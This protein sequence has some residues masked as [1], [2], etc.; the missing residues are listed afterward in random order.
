MHVGVYEEG[1]K[2]GRKE[3][4][5]EGRKAERDASR[6][7]TSSTSGARIRKVRS[8][9][10]QEDRR[11][12][13]AASAKG[14]PESRR[15]EH[16]VFVCS[17]LDLREKVGKE[18]REILPRLDFLGTCQADVV[19]ERGS[20]GGS[21]RRDD[22]LLGFDEEVHLPSKA[23]PEVGRTARV[24]PRGSDRPLRVVLAERR[25]KPLGSVF[26]GP[27]AT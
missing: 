15:V 10:R 6:K 4:R 27:L 22:R 21:Q 24:R 23:S 13:T 8:E 19:G 7:R 25:L 11:E 5:K 3:R 18:A 26:L 1:R 9:R 17:R 16:P 12:N 14:S 2:E 20:R